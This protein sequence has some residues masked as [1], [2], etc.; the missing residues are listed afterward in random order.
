MRVCPPVKKRS[1]QIRKQT[2]KR[3]HV[4][5]NKEQKLCRFIRRNEWNRNAYNDGCVG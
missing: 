4:L 3:L 2:R 5:P 1:L